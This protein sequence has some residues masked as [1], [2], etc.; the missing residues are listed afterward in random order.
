MSVESSAAVESP[1]VPGR[2][3][4][5]CSPLNTE[6]CLGWT[7]DPL[8]LPCQKNVLWVHASNHA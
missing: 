2:L 5:D 6:G 3:W 1:P 8:K 7:F 4:I